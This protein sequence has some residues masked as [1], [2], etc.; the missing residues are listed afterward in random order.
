VRRINF[1]YCSLLFFSFARRS[2]VIAFNV[3]NLTNP[4]N[5]VKGS[6]V[7]ISYNLLRILTF[8]S[9]Q[10]SKDGNAEFFVLEILPSAHLG[11]TT[12]YLYEDG[13]KTLELSKR[14]Y[15]L[16]VR[17]NYEEKAKIPAFVASS[18]ILLDSTLCPTYRKPFDI[19]AK[20]LP[21]PVKLA[22]TDSNSAKGGIN[23]H[24]AKNLPRTDSNL[25]QNAGRD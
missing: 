15:P 2:I 11:V 5:N 21:R 16:Y 1:S 20:G 19:I 3:V 13:C 23:S 7:R 6:F 10:H 22:R 9:V 18:C 25:P 12:P 24:L 17:A 14:I 4:S 8:L